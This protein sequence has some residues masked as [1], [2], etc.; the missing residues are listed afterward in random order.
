MKNSISKRDWETISAYLDRQLS[1]REQARFESRLYNDHQLQAAFDDIRQTRQ[2]L[3]S[4]PRLRAP[5]NFLLTP[6]IAGNP[7]RIP[8]LAPVFGWASAVVSFLLILVLVGDFF[9][10]GGFAPVDLILSQQNEIIVQ[11]S[12]ISESDV[13]VQP[14]ISEDVSVFSKSIVE[15]DAEAAPP[16]MRAE[17]AP[18]DTG[19]DIPTM[20][21]AFLEE[22]S[23]AEPQESELQA[24]M[25]TAA[26]T[27][28]PSLE[29]P[30]GIVA[31]AGEGQSTA[32]QEYRAPLLNRS[33]LG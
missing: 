6:E 18:M 15:S 25:K 10:D 32:H 28:E 8:R 30:E 21:S 33:Q 14:A 20:E 27:E 1:Q 7:V 29:N 2:V 31:A 19:A 11:R 3:R 4:A 5:R 24:M 22:R 9:T 13:W 12:E 26:A 17:V 23:V 16:E